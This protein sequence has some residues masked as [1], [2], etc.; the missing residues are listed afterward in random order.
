M[1]LRE[2]RADLRARFS[3]YSEDE[4]VVEPRVRDAL[5]LWHTYTHICAYIRSY[6]RLITVLYCIER[7]LHAAIIGKDP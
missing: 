3:R 5:D 1:G 4:Y 6:T 7:I 2:S